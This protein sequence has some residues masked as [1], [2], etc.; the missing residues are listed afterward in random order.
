[1]SDGGDL[2]I[3]TRQIDNEI[4]I[5][6]SDTGEG[7]DPKSAKQVFDPFFTTKPAGKGTGL[8]LAVCYGI[9]T[10]HGGRL[11]LVQNRS[12]GATFIVTLPVA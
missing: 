4:A 6:I 3:A 2:S 8:G 7:I 9:V 5:E 12:R 11:E 10:A 1:M